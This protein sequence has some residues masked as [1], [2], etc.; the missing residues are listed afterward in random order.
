[1]LPFIYLD[2]A[3]LT[4][5]PLVVQAATATTGLVRSVIQSSLAA[6]TSVLAMSIPST[7]TTD[8]TDSASAV[9]CEN[10]EI[11]WCMFHIHYIKEHKGQTAFRR[12][13]R[14]RGGVM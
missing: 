11:S 3:T 5:A 10:L 1:M 9:F 14:R 12:F 7:T 6:C 13:V 8:T 2:L 4:A